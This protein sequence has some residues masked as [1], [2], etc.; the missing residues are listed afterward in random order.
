MKKRKLKPLLPLC[1]IML[2]VCVTVGGTLAFLQVESE[3]VTNTFQAGKITYTLNLNANADGVT[4]PSK[5]ANKESTDL[6][7]TFE[8]KPEDTPSK[9]GYIFEGWYYDAACSDDKLHTAAPG[10]AITV[11]YGDK[12]D[13]NDD[14]NKVEITLYAKWKQMDFKVSFNTQADDVKNPKDQIVRF[15]E[16][17]EYYGKLPE[18]SRIG[19]TFKGWT[20]T[21]SG[22]D[23]ITNDSIVQIAADHTLYAQWS[24]KSYIIRYHA[25][26]GTGT[27]ADQEI[28]YGSLTALTKNAFTKTDYTFLGWA[29][30]STG[31]SVYLDG[32]NVLNLQESGYIDLY[33]VWAQ[34]S[35]TVYFDYNFDKEG[36]T[37]SPASKQFQNGKAYGQLPEYPM[38]NPKVNTGDST[39]YLFTG[40]YTQ[41]DG[42]TRVYASTIANTTEDHTLYAHWEKAPSNNVIQN[43]QVYNNPDDNFDGIADDVHLK[44]TCTSSF[45]K[46]NIPVKNL[47]KGQTYKITYNASNTASYGDYISGYKNSVYGSY[48]VSNSELTGG[49]IKDYAGNDILSTWYDRIEADGSND[50]SQAA[51]NDDYLQGPW[52]N[53]SITFTATQNTMYWTWDFGL[54]QDNVPYEYSI[55][56]I[57]IE[58]VVPE[59]KF[60]NKKLVLASGSVAQVKNDKVSTY[61]NNFVFDGAGYAETMYFPIT[62]LTAGSTYTITFDHKMAGALINNSSYNYGC[63]ISSVVPTKYG[64]YMDSV[65]ATWISAT[66]VFTQLNTT[67]SVT[68][69]FKATGETAYWVWNMANCSDGTDC[70]IDVKITNFSA[71]HAEGGN[72][73]YYSAAN[74]ASLDLLPEETEGT[75]ITLNYEGINDTNMEIWYPVDEQIPTAGDD[76]ELAFEPME[77]YQMADVIRVTIDGMVYEVYT[78]GEEHRQLP[79]GEETLPPAPEYNPEVNIL[80]VPGCLLTEE[81][82]IVSVEAAAIEIQDTAPDPAPPADTPTEPEEAPVPDTT[83]VPL[84]TQV[85]M[86]A[87]IASGHTEDEEVEGE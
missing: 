57:V 10:T 5:L 51:I 40:W 34:D 66:K 36:G 11:D 64:S 85:S 12:N 13:Q 29:T 43:M 75:G 58:P 50:G 45:E 63:G 7:V 69:T 71:T 49:L 41:R 83:P 6:S 67:E 44:F 23:Y 26:T 39:N 77:G 55:T 53:R 60:G 78:D 52:K 62:G 68:L 1:L 22:S 27:M 72:I 9:T 80:T 59:I 2:L 15:Q 25:N 82:Q 74:A 42:G 17:Y 76:Y 18:P 73:T 47:V 4:M 32:Q 21:P 20:L 28:K 81:T 8:L 70:T 16:K 79:E 54:M 84:Q 31:G 86:T 48:V 19:Y 37:G 56:D 46:F 61:A 3:I 87:V 65:G 30:S 24:A 14:P 33:A 38:R 35:H